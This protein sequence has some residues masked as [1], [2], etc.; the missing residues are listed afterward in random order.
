MGEYITGIKIADANVSAKAISIFRKYTNASMSEIKNKITSHEYVY[1]CETS[2]TNDLRKVKKCYKELIA[3]N[4]NA[5][6]FETINGF[7]DPISLELLGNQIQT[8]REI[9]AEIDAQCELEANDSEF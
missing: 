3:A 9:E 5:E 4:I 6:L 7:T 1:S 8:T 2:E